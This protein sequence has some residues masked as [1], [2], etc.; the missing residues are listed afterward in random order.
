VLDLGTA[1]DRPEVL[2]QGVRVFS[3]LVISVGCQ[4]LG[5]SFAASFDDTVGNVN[6]SD[7]DAV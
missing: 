3:E 7:G 1:F 6:F 2:V 5:L 4:V